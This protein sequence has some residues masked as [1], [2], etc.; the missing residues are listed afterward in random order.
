MLEPFNTGSAK[1][2]VDEMTVER[3][4]EKLVQGAK[5]SKCTNHVIGAQHSLLEIDWK[6][7]VVS[8]LARL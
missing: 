8:M 3:L 7:K 5:Q 2:P 6:R 1:R 4:N